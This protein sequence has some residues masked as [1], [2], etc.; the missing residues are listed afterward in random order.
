M[1]ITGDLGVREMS[2]IQLYKGD[3]LELMDGLIA[4]GVK[5]DA[6]LTSPPYNMNLRVRNGKYVSRATWPGHVNEFATKYQNYT[7]DLSMDDYFD[8]QD[9]FINKALKITNLMF[10][11]IQMITGNKIALFKLIGKHA[12]K[13]KEII[14]WNKINAEPAINKNTLNSQFEFIIVFENTKPFHRMFDYCRFARGAETNVWDIKRERNTKHKAGFPTELVKRI[15]NNFIPENATILDP[16]MGSGTTGAVCKN[17]NR[18]F[19]G[20]EI[21]DNYFEIA[22]ERINAKS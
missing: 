21:D 3:C 15:I 18:N 12:E 22:K 2:T 9:K 16:Y 5:V 6:V 8:F 20:I 10:Y 17:L 13:I 14:I 19:I 11:N 7:D 1:L 4:M